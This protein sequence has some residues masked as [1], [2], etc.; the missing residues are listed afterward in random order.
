MSIGLTQQIKWPDIF[1]EEGLQG[2]NEDRVNEKMA[3]RV[4]D[5]LD[6]ALLA[7]GL[8]AWANCLAGVAPLPKYFGHA[9]VAIST[10]LGIGPTHEDFMA[11][12]KTQAKR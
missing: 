2:L 10:K 1:S 5:R 6:K 8:L 7:D 3:E 12:A 11:Y 9:M 4:H